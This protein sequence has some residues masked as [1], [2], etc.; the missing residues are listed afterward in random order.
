MTMETLDIKSNLEIGSHQRKYNFH[1]NQLETVMKC[2]M[3]IDMGSF[4]VKGVLLCQGSERV[5]FECPSGGDFEATARRVQEELL[6]ISGRSADEIAGVLATGYGSKSVMFADETRS[7]IACQCIGVHALFPTARTV[8]DVGDLHSKVFNL[9]ENGGALKFLLSGNCAGG[10]GRVIQI[11][12]KVMHMKVEEIGEVSLKSEN[13]IDFSTGCVVFAE[14]EAVSRLADGVPKEDL[15]A[16]IHRAL[17]SQINSLAERLGIEEDVALVGGGALNP[18][19]VKTLKEIMGRD[20]FVPEDPH[21]TGA[22]GAALVARSLCDPNK[23][24]HA[25]ARI[26]AARSSQ[27]YDNNHKLGKKSL[28]IK[29]ISTKK[30]VRKI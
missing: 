2:V 6:F 1:E 30:I 26:P 29:P 28:T 5:T 27:E 7:D 13:P 15:L 10:S 20:I 17:S 19:L 16:G 21:M 24:S 23:G 18:G 3:G 12:A 4:R 22:Y 11:I 14:S 25:D 9:D 8:I